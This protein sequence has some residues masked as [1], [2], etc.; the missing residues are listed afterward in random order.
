MGLVTKRLFPAFILVIF[1][2]LWI[3]Q[4]A[5][6][7]NFQIESNAAIVMDQKTGRVFY[8]KNAHEKTRI[9][10][11]TKIMTALIAI[12][13][14]QLDDTVTVSKRAT[15]TEGS[16]I[17][18]QPLEKMKLE[19]L[20]YGLMLRSG[21]DAAVAIAEHVGGSLEG[22]VFLMNE[23]AEQ[24]GMKNTHFANP[25]GLDDHEDHY[26]TA[27]DMA[28]L[29]KYAMNNETF[30]EI[31]GTKVYYAP[32]PNSEWDRKWVNKNR[33]LT[34]LYKYSTGGKTGYT[35]LA[36]RT[37]VSTA[38]K[39]GMNLIA[40]TLNTPSQND[41]NEHIAMF[42]Y[43]FDQY[44][45]YPIVKKGEIDVGNNPVYD[46]H[47]YL[48]GDYVYPILPEERDEVEVKY[49][50]LKPKNDWKDEHAIPEIVGKAEIYFQDRLIH[51]LPIYFE[52]KMDEEPSFFERFKQLFSSIIGVRNDD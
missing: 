26:S 1:S 12:E 17:Y 22:F 2:V 41:W 35:K 42:E 48:K 7:D 9:A 3:P 34:G 49:R 6:A 36:K 38:S 23:K 32:D 16:S 44:E 15:K 31:F 28:L 21:N 37:L 45:Y 5:D 40:V 25:H 46:D 19:H 14:G 24:I 4:N 30:R 11:I 18:L 50:L 10:S 33:L 51:T 29:T 43:V 52:K 13:S 47:V 39:K 20:L 8:E 27:Y